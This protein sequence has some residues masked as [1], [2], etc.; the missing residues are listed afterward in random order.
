M[1]AMTGMVTGCGFALRRAPELPFRRLRLEGFVDRSALAAELRERLA[2][3]QVQVVSA[4]AA[5]DVVLQALLDRRERRVVA[6]TSV[7]QVRELQL[8]VHFHFRALTAAG[9]ELIPITELMLSRDMS[10]SES[11]A[12]GKAQEED[13]LFS[14]MQSDIVQQV[15]RRL[16][17]SLAPSK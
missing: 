6:S 16:A 13:A 10:W 12:L 2:E 11:A 1:A 15:L 14:A 7:G 4:P 9:R 3:S 17:R 5:T 8:R